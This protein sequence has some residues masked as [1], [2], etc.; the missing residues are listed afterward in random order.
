MSYLIFKAINWPITQLQITE[1]KKDRNYPIFY[2]FLNLD[3]AK[4][5]AS[6]PLAPPLV[7]SL[8]FMFKIV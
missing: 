7:A 8:D 3:L 5:R 4:G 2:L 6:A 1:T